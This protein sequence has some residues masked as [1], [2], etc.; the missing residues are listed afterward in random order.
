MGDRRT[1]EQKV[2]DHA[3]NRT[4]AWEDAAQ[5][6]AIRNEPCLATYYR[7]QAW[8]IENGKEWLDDVIVTAPL[9]PATG[10]S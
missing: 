4:K 7:N 5:R 9:A 1:A 8:R 2:L 10:R 3:I 6:A